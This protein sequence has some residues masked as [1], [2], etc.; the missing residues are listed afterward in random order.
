MAKYRRKIPAPQD[1]TVRPVWVYYLSRDSLD[2][3]LNA[4]CSLW[5]AKPLRTHVA[6]RVT[7]SST[8]GHLG[9][10]R[11]DEILK[12]AAFKTYPETD[13]ELIVV[14]TRPTKEELDESEK[15]AGIRR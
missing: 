10:F 3:A 15:K 14:E 12:W 1:D 2:G 11:P 7:W 6:Q 8:S 13:R 4:L 9:N 5:F